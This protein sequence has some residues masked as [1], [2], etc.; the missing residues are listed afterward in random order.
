MW[1]DFLRLP[2]LKNDRL[3]P[4]QFCNLSSDNLRG[5]YPAQIVMTTFA[6]IDANGNHS[7]RVLDEFTDGSFVTEWRP[8]FP[9]RFPTWDV[10]FLIS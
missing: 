8:M 7:D 9:L 1:A 2:R 4:G 5:L 10:R 3:Y 6:L